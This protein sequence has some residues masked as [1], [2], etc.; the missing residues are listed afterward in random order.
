MALIYGMVPTHSPVSLPDQPGVFELLVKGYPDRGT[1]HLPMHGAEL[2]SGGDAIPSAAR[3]LC[4]SIELGWMSGI[5]AWVR[6]KGG[7][8]AVLSDGCAVADG[9]I[10]VHAANMDCAPT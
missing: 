2:P 9:S 5:G 7:S 4:D 6:G 1:D 3:A 10:T 8:M